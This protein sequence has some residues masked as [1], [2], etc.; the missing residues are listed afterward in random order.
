MRKAL[1][2]TPLLLLGISA[3]A[4]PKLGKASIDKV[5]DAMTVEE[6]INLVVGSAGDKS[7][8][9]SATVGDFGALVPGAAGQTNAIPRLGI[10]ATTLADGPAGLR[11]N[12]TRTGTR[13]TFYCTHFP[14]E[15]LMGATWNTA[16]MEEVGA[17]IGYETLHYGVDVLLAPATNI[18][19]NPLCGRNFEYLSEDPLL[20][21]KMCAAEIRGLQSNGI[22]V[23]VKHFALNNQETNRTGNDARVTEKAI[24]EIYLKPFEI[25]VK[26]GKPWTI[27][28]S[29]NRIN[30]T[31]ASESKWLL[32]DRLRRDWGF[33]GLVMSDWYGGTDP[34]A[35]L[36]AGNDLL[37]PGSK[38]QVK[39]LLKAVENGSLSTKDLD[40]NVKRI[41]EY[42]LK[43]PA[44]KGHKP[45]NKPSLEEHAAITR[46][47]AT[48]GMVLLKNNMTLP[49]AGCKAAVFGRTS[50]SFIAGGTGSGDVHH[51]YVV[52]LIQ[53]LQNAGFTIDSGLEK[54]YRAYIKKKDKGPAKG[55]K[56]F[57]PIELIPEMPLDDVDLLALADANDVAMITIGKTSG[58][59]EDRS[60]TSNYGL[61]DDEI[62]MITK[63]C[64][65]FHSA[66]KKVIV[67]L[68]VCGVVD[69]ISW[70]ESPDAV[71]CAWLPG[72]EGGNSV[73]DILTGRVNPSGRLPMT[74]PRAYKDVPSAEDFP[75]PDKISR[76][77]SMK[78]MGSFVGIHSKPGR[79]K[80]YDYTEYNDDIFVGYRHYTTKD[81]K[82][83][84][85]F[86]YGLSYTTF[87]YSDPVLKG[88]SV[89]VTVRNTGDAAGKEVVQVYSTSNK[90]GRPARELIGFAKTDLLPKG[91]SQTIE[92][93][94]YEYKSGMS[95]IIARNAADPD[96]VTVINNKSLFR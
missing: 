29:Y 86:G 82:V 21:G 18:M 31:M 74:W 28:S 44:F 54:T 67:I 50:Y 40:R 22:G 23:S 49:L 26:E 45:D 84:F 89:F 62:S 53:G 20:A 72:Q 46:T 71:L 95:L 57:F 87:E 13:N 1:I 78:S 83:S 73:A 77:K 27:M 41:L 51:A 38:S 8:T 2:I 90:S 69:T 11:I 64:G 30:G 56:A 47:A 66:G 39:D 19:R 76:F 9:A 37:M 70:I 12:P 15:M 32:E 3:A 80:N 42:I 88:G 6:K 75:N 16:L 91:A 85:P 68:N 10:P 81:V 36:K 61:T 55:L 52:D 4:Q 60:I 59:F 96:P 63:V 43:T 35:M 92:I 24:E 34:V 33:D 65:A 17:A 79:T 58:E 48:E 5:I 7:T 94:L 14:V 93:P 25:A